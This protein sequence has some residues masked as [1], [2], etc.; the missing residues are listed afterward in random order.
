MR[1]EFVSSPFCSE[2]DTL[3]GCST[4]PSS[5]FNIKVLVTGLDLLLTR[6]IMLS[7]LELKI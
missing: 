5:E 1:V 4:F 2:K 6:I 3:S 7:K